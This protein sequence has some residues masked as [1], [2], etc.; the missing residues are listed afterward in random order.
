MQVESCVSQECDQSHQTREKVL[1]LKACANANSND[2][3]QTH[4][5]LN[6][7]LETK[8]AFCNIMLEDSAQVMLTVPLPLHWEIDG[9]K[10][11]TAR[12]QNCG[13]SFH[14]SALVWHMVCNDMRCPVC[15]IGPGTALDIATSLPEFLVEIFELLHDAQS[16]SSSDL[17]VDSASSADSDDDDHSLASMSSDSGAMSSFAGSVQCFSSYNLNRWSDVRNSV[18]ESCYL[19]SHTQIIRVTV[20]IFATSPQNHQNILRTDCSAMQ[21]NQRT[22]VNLTGF[23]SRINFSCSDTITL[24]T[25]MQYQLQRQLKRRVCATLAKHMQQNHALS[26]QIGIA[27][28]L[29]AFNTEASIFAFCREFDVTPSNEIIWEILQTNDVSMGLVALQSR[30]ILLQLQ[31]QW[32]LKHARETN[33]P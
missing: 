32:M 19:L 18:L 23:A 11:Q 24:V 16:S 3:T 20:R 7:I 29:G 13:H 22:V 4:N 17:D 2:E 1:T 25:Q 26:L 8:S 12:I 27:L 28:N 9:S 5:T 10:Y 15:R 14:C 30:D 21:Q 31:W 33:V 6:I